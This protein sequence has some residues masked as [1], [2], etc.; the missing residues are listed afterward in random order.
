MEIKNWFKL[1]IDKI[2]MKKMEQ[3]NS[4]WKLKWNW[5]WKI[6]IGIEKKSELIEN[7]NTK[8]RSFSIRG[9]T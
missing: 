3:L 6:E 4:N 1:K 9:L 8:K 7:C 2:E 5:N